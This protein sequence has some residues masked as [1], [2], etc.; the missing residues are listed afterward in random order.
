[1]IDREKAEIGVL[2]TMEE[3]TGPM[4]A[5]AAG[6]GFYVSPWDKKAY[7]RLQL[8]TVAE[9]MDGKSLELPPSG[10]F[11]TFKKAPKSAPKSDST[12]MMFE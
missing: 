6:A 2:I 12:P 7:P 3:P 5:E 8:R 4:K 11:R 10:D 9:L 1:M